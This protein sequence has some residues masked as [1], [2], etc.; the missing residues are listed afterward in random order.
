MFAKRVVSGLAIVAL[1][2]IAIISSARIVRA[3]SQSVPNLSGAWELIEFDGTTKS[4]IGSKFPNLTLEI[5]QTA[6][7]IT[8]KQKRIKRGSVKTPEYTYF[9][10]GRGETNTGQI[11]LWLPDEYWVESV[12]LW[13]AGKLLI[14]YKAQLGV[15][16]GYPAKGVRQPTQRKN[17]GSR[18]TVRSWC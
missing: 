9:P 2:S 18:L 7:E 5:S 6:S 8:I 1:T 17:G 16:N 15:M 11:K 4:Q 12:T 13:Q 10:D 3:Q 14:S